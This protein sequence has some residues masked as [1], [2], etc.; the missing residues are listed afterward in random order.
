MG[1]SRGKQTDTE[2]QYKLRSEYVIKYVESNRNSLRVMVTELYHTQKGVHEP[3]YYSTML[4]GG[5]N[6]LMNNLDVSLISDFLDSLMTESMIVAALG[7]AE[8][9]WT[10]TYL[11][12]SSC[13][14]ALWRE[15]YCCRA[16][17]EIEGKVKLTLSRIKVNENHPS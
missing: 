15:P 9:G 17:K 1:A 13:V 8:T 6:T 11:V 10:T 4:V 5:K 3:P 7:T 2:T 12:N 16:L 14:R